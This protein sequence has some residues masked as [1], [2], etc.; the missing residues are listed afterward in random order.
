[1]F[2]QV[3]IS[4]VFIHGGFANHGIHIFLHLFHELFGTLAISQLKAD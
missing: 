3:F 4:L 1:V 2:Y